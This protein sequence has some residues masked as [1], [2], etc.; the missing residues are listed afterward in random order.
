VNKENLKRKL[1]E[2][3]ISDKHYSL[4]GGLPYDK[5]CL[6]NNK[7]IWEVYYSERG[8]KFDLKIF[9]NEEEACQYFYDWLI[10]SLKFDGLI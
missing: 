8:G 5:I 6:A 3:K 9:N 4:E 1:I 2:E 10:K 7:G